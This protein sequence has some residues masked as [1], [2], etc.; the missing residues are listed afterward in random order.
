MSRRGRSCNLH[1]LQLRLT[2]SQGALEPHPNDFKT[3]NKLQLPVKSRQRRENPRQ[4]AL[5][6]PG[7]GDSFPRLAL[8]IT[9]SSQPPTWT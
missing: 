1:G 3:Q 5:L 4:F 7:R 8:S 9:Q 6:A 2:A